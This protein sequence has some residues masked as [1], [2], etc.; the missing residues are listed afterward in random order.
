MP[1]SWILAKKI[2]VRRGGVQAGRM[3]RSRSPREAR[4]PR[5]ELDLGSQNGMSS[6]P[7]PAGTGAGW[8]SASAGMSPLAEAFWS[9]EPRY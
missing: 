9:R 7:P 5:G 8:K 3:G 1:K 4:C 2:E 6:A